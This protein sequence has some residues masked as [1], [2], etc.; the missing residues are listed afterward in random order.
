MTSYFSTFYCSCFPLAHPLASKVC[1]SRVVIGAGYN[2]DSLGAVCY[3]P[4]C[5]CVVGVTIAGDLSLFKFQ[6][7]A[8]VF[9]G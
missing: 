8:G 4:C 6:H 1:T 5:C 9:L 7:S 3:S 2:T